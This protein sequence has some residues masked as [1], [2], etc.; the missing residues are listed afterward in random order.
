MYENFNFASDD[1]ENQKKRMEKLVNSEIFFVHQLM[2]K[3]KSE[4][5]D[6]REKK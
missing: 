3:K 4:K 5:I 2:S 1:Q 6:D